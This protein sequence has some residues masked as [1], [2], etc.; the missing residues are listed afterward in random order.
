[1]T[2]LMDI[3]AL[4]L[5]KSENMTNFHLTTLFKMIFLKF[6]AFW[7]KFL[8]QIKNFIKKTSSV[9]REIQLSHQKRQQNSI[10]FQKARDT[11]V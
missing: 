5:N 8:D 3:R 7:V 9:N 4:R 1:M 6:G 10:P 2:F 11:L